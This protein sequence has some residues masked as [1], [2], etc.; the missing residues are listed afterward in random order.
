MQEMGD[1][2]YKLYE[3]NDSEG[4]ELEQALRRIKWEEEEEK[5][6][7]EYFR[8]IE[9]EEKNGYKRLTVAELIEE[10]KMAK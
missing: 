4:K 9:E 1:K 2:Y 3:N 10:R 7:R 8:V 5:A 6:K